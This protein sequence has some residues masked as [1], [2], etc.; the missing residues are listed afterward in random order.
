[1]NSSSG[2]PSKAPAREDLELIDS[3]RSD[4]EDM[5]DL[6]GDEEPTSPP[7]STNTAATI[8]EQGPNRP[9]EPSD[10]P[11]APIRG[12]GAFAFLGS[13]T[14]S[15][16]ARGAQKRKKDLSSPQ[17][18]VQRRPKQHTKAPI[19]E[20]IPNID[21]G[22]TDTEESLSKASALLLVAAVTESN[23]IRKEAIRK[24]ARELERIQ[25]GVI[26]D[27]PASES[28]FESLLGRLERIE[29]AISGPTGPTTAPTTVKTNPK[30]RGATAKAASYAT[31]AASRP[32][33]LN[34]SIFSPSA[35]PSS[36]PFLGS[37]PTPTVQIGPNKPKST[38][39]PWIQVPGKPGRKEKP[40]SK[41]E[42]RQS[43]QLI[44]IRKEKGAFNAFELRNKVNQAFKEQKGVSGLVLAT[45]TES[46]QNKNLILTTTEG[47]SAE[48]L[49]QN[50]PIWEPFFE[51]D[52]IQLNQTWFNIVAHG[53]PI[54]PFREAGSMAFLKEEIEGFNP[55]Q[56]EGLPRWITSESKRE[57][58][59]VGSIVFAVSSEDRQ[60]E[61]LKLQRIQIAG[62]TAKIVKFKDFS[63]QCT[64]CWRRGHLRADCTTK[65][66]RLCAGPHLSKDHTCLESDCRA[67]G[68][69]CL[70]T[71]PKCIN[72]KLNHFADSP[73]CSFNA[74]RQSKS[75]SPQPSGSC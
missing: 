45:I 24:I 2:S 47:F 65:A 3:S 6:V 55:I 73:T 9:I 57:N 46:F 70:H 14:E 37:K 28:Q 66:C 23:P 4:S 54:S 27:L 41:R 1:M 19:S 52:R 17:N 11:I 39:S 43:R 51:F 16:Q 40:L 58:S 56:I 60:K 34:S 53:V 42:Q 25:K 38:Q 5:M 10:R 8:A 75:Q 62:S 63:K 15:M 68:K 32:V 18:N 48:F 35:P 21:L 67:I 30:S 33:G 44:L 74:T 61:V 69:A 71:T 29:K 20:P 12:G 49:S 59:L 36:T 7:P 13:F 22:V 72:C 50:R 26:P 31:V 64:S